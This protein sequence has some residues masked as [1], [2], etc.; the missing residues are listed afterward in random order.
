MQTNLDLVKI[1]G[2]GKSQCVH[3][4]R[5]DEELSNEKLKKLIC[6]KSEELLTSTWPNN[7]FNR[8]AVKR[9]NSIHIAATWVKMFLIIGKE[10]WQKIR[11]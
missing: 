7:G 9:N 5:K 10:S 4:G 3:A 6:Q 2:L 8:L 1:D 11:K